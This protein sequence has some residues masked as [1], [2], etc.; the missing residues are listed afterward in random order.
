MYHHFYSINLKSVHGMGRAKISRKRET[1]LSVS[2]RGDQENRLVAHLHAIQQIIYVRVILIPLFLSLS[3]LSISPK[4]SSL[5]I[6]LYS[7]FF[8]T[9]HI[10]QHAR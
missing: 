7:L 4:Y 8:R 10:A 1:E 2:L 5:Y 9:L 3:S 6:D